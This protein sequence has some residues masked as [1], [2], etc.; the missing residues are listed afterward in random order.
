VR[1][2]VDVKK[3]EP[4]IVGEVFRPEGPAPEAAPPEPVADEPQ[5]PVEPEAPAEPEALPE[6]QAPA[7]PEA[8][9]EPA[10]EVA[11]GE[12]SVLLPEVEV[13]VQ[14]QAEDAEPGEVS[15]E[16]DPVSM[17]SLDEPDSGVSEVFVVSD[18]A[19]EVV[20]EI[21]M[22]AR[23]DV[24]FG[25]VES[26]A[27]VEMA[28]PPSPPA[29]P[30]AVPGQTRSAWMKRSDHE[31]ARATYLAELLEEM[32]EMGA[33]DLHF[34]AGSPPVV[35][36]HG[37]LIRLDPHPPLDPGELRKVVYS[38]LS[39]KQREV[40]EN[41]LE[42]DCAYSLPGVSRFRVNVYFQRDSI[43]AAFRAIPMEIKSP[44]ALG[45][46]PILRS[47]AHM[48]R[49]F[50]L[51]TGPTGSGKSTTLASVIDVVNHERA[52]HIMTIEDPI[53]FMHAHDRAMVNQR[54]LGADTKTFAN[55]LKHVLRQDPDVILVGEMRDLE[56][57]SVALT[58]AET[59]HLVFAT[60][61]TQD[62][63][64]SI[65]R[66][67]DVFPPHQQQQVRVQLAASL[68]GIVSQQLLPATDVL[69]RV[70]AVEVLVATPAVRNLIREGKTHQIYSS[71]QAGAQ[72]GMQ[73]MDQ[74][75]ATLVRAGKVTR[76]IAFER[77]HH[78]ED[79]SRL[80]GGATAP[81]RRGG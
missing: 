58:A 2:E 11:E 61:H 81:G 31:T 62:A 1:G 41:E 63:P 23:I 10:A 5:A 21:V 65:D 80:L 79:L 51:V 24:P 38:I 4:W 16:P 7:E 14:A 34:T 15:G 50:V 56:T 35:R 73:T 37:D 39:Q 40:L 66:V 18:A 20:E 71:I 70:V 47:F 59:G 44:E 27:A 9:E 57:I 29:R 33:S 6:P 64:Q 45:L 60:L 78:M 17:I 3:R 22:P 72:Y 55:A 19:P 32:V 77:C 67:I 28:S 75:L 26:A 25:P 30:E 42:L 12:E 76:E 54:E 46:P 68:Q 48:Q 8:G 36:V 53:E 69:S 43:G 74:H 49:G 13:G 52:V